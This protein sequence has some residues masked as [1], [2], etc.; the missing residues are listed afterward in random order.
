MT[1][2]EWLETMVPFTMLNVMV[3]WLLIKQTPIKKWGW[4]TWL[5]LH[6]P[7]NAADVVSTLLCVRAAGQD[8]TQ[9]EMSA[10]RYLA[11]IMGPATAMIACKLSFMLI[12]LVWCLFARTREQRDF[13]RTVVAFTVIGVTL[14]A[15][16]NFY[17]LLV[18]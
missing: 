13:V 1:V 9:L 8:W 12:V 7:A 6:I 3:T 2:R 15:V 16:H 18:P 11:P 14:A 10:M 4:K 5:L 17:I